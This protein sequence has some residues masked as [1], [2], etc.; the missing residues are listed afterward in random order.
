MTTD[1]SNTQQAK[2]AKIAEEIKNG[3]PLNGS[4]KNPVQVSVKDLKVGM[5]DSEAELRAKTA[6][7]GRIASN[8]T[9]KASDATQDTQTEEPLK[10]S[11]ENSVQVATEDLKVGKEDSEADLREKT[12]HVGRI[13]SHSTAKN[14]S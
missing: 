2:A 7:V 6:H 5:E 14:S 10:G 11:G 1:N 9:A 3:Q 4:D 13:A 8:V 12:K